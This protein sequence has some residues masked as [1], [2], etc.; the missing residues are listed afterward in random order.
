M[1][2][3]FCE[4]NKMEEQAVSLAKSLGW[5]VYQNSNGN[6]IIEIPGENRKI[7]LKEE[8]SNEWLL[9]SNQIPQ[10]ILKP[11]EASEFIKKIEEKN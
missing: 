7:L 11:V 1:Y 10:A 2:S 4:K 6:Q 9:I 8:Q 3:N 5:N